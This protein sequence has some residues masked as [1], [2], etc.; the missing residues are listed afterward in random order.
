M[1][2]HQLIAAAFVAVF[3]SVGSPQPTFPA[4]HLLLTRILFSVGIAYA[5]APIPSDPTAFGAFVTLQ[6]GPASLT[7]NG[8][9]HFERN[10][11]KLRCD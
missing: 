3:L 9:A 4:A 10:V 7:C 5:Q 8:Y 1:A 6:G 2:T 11:R